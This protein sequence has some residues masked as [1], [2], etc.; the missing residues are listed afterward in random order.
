EGLDIF[1][2]RHAVLQAKRDGDGS[3]L[4]QQ[5]NSS[6]IEDEDDED[7]LEELLQAPLAA[8]AVTV[9]EKI[10]ER[11]IERVSREREKLPNSRQGYTQKAAVGGQ[12]VYL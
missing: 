7:A 8:K 4:S 3:K 2:E 5:L 12:K 10:I 11:V 1:L 9:T 6:L